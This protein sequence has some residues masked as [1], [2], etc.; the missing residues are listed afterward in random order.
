MGDDGGAAGGRGRDGASSALR[1]V[2]PEGLVDGSQVGGERR[3][4]KDDVK[5]FG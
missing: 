3:R 5:V 2:E 4:I 1:V